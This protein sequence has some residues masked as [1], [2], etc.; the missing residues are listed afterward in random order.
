MRDEDFSDF[1]NI[2]ANALVAGTSCLVGLVMY[3]YYETCDPLATKRIQKVDQ[4]LPF[5]V[6][7]VASTIPGLPG[8][9]I[10]G[11]FSAALSSMSTG[12]NT[13]AGTIY[14]DFVRPYY[15]NASEK[16]ASDVMKLLVVILG[17]VFVSLVFVVEH[18]G[19]V[20]RIS[21]AVSGRK[22]D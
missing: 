11:I 18:M 10:A 2:V 15:P 9:F 1:K 5:F 12:M 22:C 13:L 6:M 3:A 17:V 4:I 8:I 16:H 19:Q 20:F 14:E 7:E 21:I